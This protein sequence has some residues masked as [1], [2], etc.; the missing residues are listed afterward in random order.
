MRFENIASV[1]GQWDG[2]GYP[3]TYDLDWDNNK[4]AYC[5]TVSLQ[6][7]KAELMEMGIEVGEGYDLTAE[8]CD[9]F[10]RKYVGADPWH[11]VRLANALAETDGGEFYEDEFYGICGCQI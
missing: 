5:M 11:V 4:E 9:K 8:Y 1:S 10:G 6:Y 7:D 3:I 2:S